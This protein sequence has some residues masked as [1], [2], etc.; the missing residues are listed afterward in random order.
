VQAAVRA[1]GGPWG[2]ATRLSEYGGDANQLQVSL[3]GTGDGA[4]VWARVSQSHP[5]VQAVGLDGSAP[6]L[7]SLSIPEAATMERPVSVS[8]SPFDVW[9]P[10]SSVRWSFAAEAEVAGVA[11]AHT[12]G[13]PGTYPVTLAVT[14]AL[15]RVSHAG[16]SVRVYPKARASRNVAVRGRRALLRVHC[17][18]PA[19]CA[20]SAKLKAAV[21]LRRGRR[22][23]RR[24]ATIAR[25]RF[26]I[27]GLGTRVVGAR[28]SRPGL[29][30]VRGAGRHGLKAQLAGPGIKH[31][32]LALFARGRRHRAGRHPSHH[33]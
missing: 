11:A 14:D 27:G 3:D 19:G 16:A 32:L 20:G 28:L 5:I 26:A 7:R 8:V 25:A 2:A 23:V 18:S 22:T 12:F 31:R 10:I 1:P 15:G 6:S 17:P 4:A 29:N 33:R 9:S 30:A 13:R 21:K 24:R